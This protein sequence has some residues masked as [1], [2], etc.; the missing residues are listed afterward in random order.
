MGETELHY[1]SAG[2]G[3]PLLWVHGF[4]GAGPDWRHLFADP[5]SGFQ[6]IA[7]DLPGHGRSRD[8]GQF[9][10]RSCGEKL[11]RLLDR[12]QIPKVKAIGLSGGGISLL[13]LARLAPERVSAMVLVSVPPRFPEQ[14]RAIQ[15]QFSAAMVTAEEMSAMR[16]RHPGGEGQIE[17]LFT[18]CRR[19]ADDEHDVNF[20]PDLLAAVS[21][22]TLVV[23]GD[24]DPL[25][26]VSLGVELRE[27]L[28]YSHLWVLPNAGHAPIFGEAAEQFSAVALP[29][30]RGRWT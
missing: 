13:H 24:R 26:P 11:R 4:M 25:Y 28:P 16:G 21:A 12:L 9:S 7:P 2:E 30:L 8:D 29:F 15:G 10:F 27:S 18:W 20:T 19:L 23:L 22:D 14:A 1:E 5:P 3:E 6:V 17:R